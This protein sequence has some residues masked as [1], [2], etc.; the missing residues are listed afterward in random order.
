MLNFHSKSTVIH[1]NNAH[2][3][4][5]AEAPYVNQLLRALAKYRFGSSYLYVCLL[6]L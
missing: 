3:V 2:A 1:L 6:L 4:A 5:L